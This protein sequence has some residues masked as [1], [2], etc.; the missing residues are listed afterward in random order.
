MIVVSILV[1]YDQFV[2]I[3]TGAIRLYLPRESTGLL[4]PINKFFNVEL[5]AINPIIETLMVSGF[6]YL[7]LIQGLKKRSE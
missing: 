1:V 2:L 4:H 3:V 6:L 5:F 7:I